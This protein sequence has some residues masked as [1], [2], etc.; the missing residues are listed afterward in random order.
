MWSRWAPSAERTTLVTVSITGLPY[1]YIWWF[2]FNKIYPCTHALGLC[3]SSQGE[4][5][6]TSLLCLLQACSPNMVLMGAG[7]PYFIALVSI[8]AQYSIVKFYRLEVMR[9]RHITYEF[10]VTDFLFHLSYRWFKNYFD[11]IYV[12]IWTLQC[13]C[14]CFYSF[15]INCCIYA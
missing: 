13:S 1:N 2:S 9:Q 8:W 10:Y 14:C 7:P 4:A 15:A 6:D 12:F 5:L 3:L 11:F